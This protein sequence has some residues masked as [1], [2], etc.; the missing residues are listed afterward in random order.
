MK[1][2]VVLALSLCLVTS[3]YAQEENDQTPKV[4]KTDHYIGVQANFLLREILNFGG[5]NLVLQNPYGFVYHMNSKKS[6]YGFRL[7]IGPRVYSS[8]NRDGSATIST[9]GYNI[10]GRVGF[11]K[12]IKLDD[13]WETGIGIDALFNFRD[14]KTVSDQMNFQQVKSEVKTTDQA[15]GGGPMAYLRYYIRKNI[16]IGTE[17]SFYFLSGTNQSKTK[18]IDNFGNVTNESDDKDKF[19]N[20]QLNLPVSLYLFIKI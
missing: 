16:L 8:T 13:K 2:V 1:K 4:K 3:L 19:T 14:D 7:G 5:N 20:G 17:A 15:V 11:D 18:L 12:R 6:G 9:N 10:S